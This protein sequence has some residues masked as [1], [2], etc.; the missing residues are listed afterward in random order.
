MSG[1]SFLKGVFLL[2]EAEGLISL[3]R[4]LG[5]DTQNFLRTNIWAR[6]F[7]L[8]LTIFFA[9]NITTSSLINPFKK[10]YFALIVWV[11]L[12]M[13]SKINYIFKRISFFVILVTFFLGKYIEYLELAILNPESKSDISHLSPKELEKYSDYAKKLNHLEKVGVFICVLSILIGFMVLLGNAGKN[14][15]SVLKNLFVIPVCY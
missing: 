1:R 13:F 11:L 15:M 7:I 3:T 12:L 2:I 5:C 10:V 4:S 9:I 6:N 14:R 8:I